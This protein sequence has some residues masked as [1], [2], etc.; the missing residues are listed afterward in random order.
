MR[1]TNWLCVLGLTATVAAG[2]VVPE[3]LYYK[4]NEGAGTTTLNEANPALGT[5]PVGTLNGALG[6]GPGR[7]GTGLVGVGGSGTVDYVNTGYTV[8][9]TGSSWTMEFWFNPAPTTGAT[10]Y[11]LVGIPIGG[12]WRVFTNGS[13]GGAIT[14]SG[15]G[16]STVSMAGATPAVGTWVHLAWV[17]D[18]TAAT[19]TITPY[20]NGVPGTPVAQT[21]VPSLSTGQLNVGSQISG[22]AGL[23][24]T[25]DEFRLWSRARTAVEI[26]TSYLSELNA[27]N[28]LSAVTS[29]SGAGDLTLSLASITAGTTEGFVFLSTDTSGTVG[30]GP[31]FGIR[32]D[33]LTWISLGFPAQPGNPFHFQTGVPGL[34]PDSPFVAPPGT[35][36][37]LAGVTTDLAAVVLAPGFAYL[38]RS[39]VV[40]VTW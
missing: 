5:A 13:A 2:Q 31:F 7:L 39:N 26:A 4:F 38:G 20:V 30:T 32:P 11:Y 19:R 9:L 10:L 16:I 40:R 8:N 35:L 12:S 14:M 18:A 29:G 17:Y 37:G 36:S 21:G 25:M 27:E 3:V 28:I 24:G 6:W 34:F 22:S 1:I 33:A 23:N 15:T